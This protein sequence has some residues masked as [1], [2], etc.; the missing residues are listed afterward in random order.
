MFFLLFLRG[1]GPCPN[2]KNPK[3]KKKAE[4]D[5]QQKHPPAQIALFG[6]GVVFFLLFG[7]GGVFIFRL[8]GRAR[9]RTCVFS[10][11][12]AGESCLFICSLGG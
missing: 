1:R 8:L 5:F 11:A 6:R 7:R 3:K 12:W 9:E 2:R 10:A 4:F